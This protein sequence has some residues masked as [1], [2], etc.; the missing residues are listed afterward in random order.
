MTYEEALSYIHG[1]HK[2]GI[3]LGL[4]NMEMLLSLMGNPHKKLSYVHIAGTNGKG[5]TAS[6]INSVLMEAGYKTGIYTS[7]YIERFTERIKVNNIE[8]PKGRLASITDSVKRHVNYMV[9]N[10]EN[11]PTEF[12]ILTA[13]ALQYYYEESCDIV[14]LEVGLGGRYDST[15]V[16]DT[17]EVAVIT[18]ISLDHTG[19]LGSTLS[20][21]AYQK[22][23]IIKKGGDVVVYPSEQSVTDVFEKVCQS[24]GARI[25]KVDFTGLDIKKYDESGQVFGIINASFEGEYTDIEIGLIGNHQAHNAVVAIK[26]LEV[27]SQK[28]YA[29]TGSAIREGL[30][31]AI[32][33]GRLEVLLKKP[34]FIIDGAHNYEGAKALIDTL[35]AY[36]PEKRRVF[37]IGV[38]KD[39]D[40]NKIL[41][42]SLGNVN[43]VITVTP[44]NE[45]AL[46]GEELAYHVK[47][48]C[49][50][51]VVSDTIEEAISQSLFIAGN[52]DLICAFGSLYYIGEI[53][54][55]F[56]EI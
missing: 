53:R 39:K 19:I 35:D 28:G 7:P 15:N 12:E 14:V 29:I 16:I 31:K 17:P 11:H 27:L 49:K 10:G 4:Y 13:V 54:R 34:V 18:T 21:I 8:I 46:A 6:F 1:T 43:T 55:H 22:A 40:Y 38:M 9:A 50:N 25:T 44:Q 20:E 32:W 47:H 37:I 48:Y 30:K 5:S 42:Y 41:E 24:E 36:F 3:K 26:A 45:R 2:F 23:G 52:E 51:V 56:K 33:P